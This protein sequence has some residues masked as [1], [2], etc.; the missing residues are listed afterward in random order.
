MNVPRNFVCFQKFVVC[1]STQICNRIR[2]NTFQRSLTSL[3]KSKSNQTQVIVVDDGSPFKDHLAWTLQTFPSVQIIQRPFNGG[4]SKCKNT[5]LRI[6]KEKHSQEGSFFA[7]LADDDIEYFPGFEDLYVSGLSIESSS[8]GPINILSACT[9]SC[10][11]RNTFRV[12]PQTICNGYF[13]CFHSSHLETVGYF[14][15]F[16]KKYGHEH[17]WWTLRFQLCVGQ[18]FF[19][20]V[21]SSCLYVKHGLGPPSLNHSEMLTGIRVNENVFDAERKLAFFE[22]QDLVE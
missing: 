17:V 13:V 3:M 8:Y 14:K 10:L 15:V 9:K 1:I 6:M 4:L 21:A 16:P 12:E 22:K 2:Q 18:R 7:A 11:S 19:F 20:D 5:C